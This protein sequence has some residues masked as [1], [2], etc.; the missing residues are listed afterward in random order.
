MDEKAQLGSSRLMNGAI[1]GFMVG[2]EDSI[3]YS[4]V[5]LDANCLLCTVQSLGRGSASG[6]L[7]CPRARSGNKFMSKR[8]RSA[9]RVKLM[10][11][12]DECAILI[13]T[14]QFVQSFGHT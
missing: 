11:P 4:K 10:A 9:R 1:R 6:S 8:A 2:V 5:A 12:S 14:I 3:L 7:L 13:P